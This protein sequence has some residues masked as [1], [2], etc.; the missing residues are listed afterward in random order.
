M[1]K[2][3]LTAASVATTGLMVVAMPVF[4]AIDP[5]YDY[6]LDQFV[7]LF[8]NGAAVIAGII[9]LIYLVIAGIKYITSSGDPGKTEEA[10]KQI[11]A[12]II[13]LAIVV[14]AYALTRVITTL[15]GIG[16]LS[17]DEFIKGNALHNKA[18]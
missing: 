11:I 15:L 13:G 6:D 2:K 18:E 5:T 3:L 7:N 1:T 17:I 12:A 9:V 16:D 4:A 10:Q 14:L 8:I